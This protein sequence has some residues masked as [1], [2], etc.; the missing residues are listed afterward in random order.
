MVAGLQQIH[1]LP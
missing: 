1:K